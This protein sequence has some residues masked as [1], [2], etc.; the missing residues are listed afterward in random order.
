MLIA[1]GA[2]AALAGLGALVLGRRP[3]GV[4]GWNEAFFV[5]GALAAALLFP[6]SLV[7]GPF[8]L[9]ALA[10]G[11]AATGVPGLVVACLRPSVGGPAQAA[12]RPGTLEV[13][14]GAWIALAFVA[15]SVANFRYHLLWDGLHIWAT[16]AMLLVDD[17]CLSP[18]LWGGGGLE[19][20]VGRVAAYPPF[21]PLLEAFVATVRGSF[22]F[23]A[24]KPVFILFYASLLVGTW[25]AGQSLGGRRAGLLAAALVAALPPL[26]TRWAAGG[27]A[28]M[29]QAAALV[30]LAGALLRCEDAGPAWRRPAPWLL[31]AVVSVK[32]EGTI[33][34][35]VALGGCFGAAALAGGVRGVARVVRREA[36]GFVVA[37]AFL[38]Q[39]FA[40][41]RWTSAFK[42]LEHRS[43]N[44]ESLVA[45]IG[46]VPEVARLVLA[47]MSDVPKWGF[48][49]PALAAASALLLVRGD[50]PRRALTLA[51][52][53]AV[54]LYSST[55]LFTNWPVA[56]HVATALDRILSQLAPAAVLVVVAALLPRSA[57]SADRREDDAAAPPSGAP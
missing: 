23:D 49:W 4:A 19:G 44:A 45:A 43:V 37:A 35:L 14:L 10:T 36:G 32:S 40:Y 11:V 1:A 57:G 28:D 42:D 39:R 7:L 20:R 27:Y 52:L 2:G 54:A 55:F 53:A 22:D 38:A 15:F 8:A 33:L 25:S 12:G 31:G 16:K 50:A 51:T 9:L 17:G 26:S 34:A 29:P 5:G 24:V 18:V 6:F 3:R 21:V 48:L 47:E 56:V 30:A 46:R 41:S 13:L